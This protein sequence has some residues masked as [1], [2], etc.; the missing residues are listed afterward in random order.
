MAQILEGINFDPINK[1]LE[2]KLLPQKYIYYNADCYDIVEDDAGKRKSESYLVRF[3]LCDYL[4]VV[5]IQDIFVCHGQV[6][7]RMF[8]N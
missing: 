3:T 5:I 8:C 7:F 1:T 6:T 4:T 2:S